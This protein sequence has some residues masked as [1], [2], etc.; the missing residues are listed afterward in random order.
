MLWKH[1]KKLR[2]FVMSEEDFDELLKDIHF[3][4]LQDV[5][6]ST[7]YFFQNYPDIM[8]LYDIRDANELHNLMKK[9]MSDTEID[10]NRMPHIGI[11][12]SFFKADCVGERRYV[13]HTVP[14]QRPAEDEELCT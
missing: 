6:I 1:G 11:G 13:L 2:Y 14:E 7:R 3:D 4:E 5:E 12:N 10:F 8:E 9:H